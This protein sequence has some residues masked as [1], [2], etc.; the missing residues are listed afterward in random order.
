[1][2][3]FISTPLNYVNLYGVT[4]LAQAV[5]QELVDV[6][7]LILQR[8][9]DPNIEDDAGNIALHLAAKTGSS[10]MVRDR[11]YLL[12]LFSSLLGDF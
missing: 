8:G 5:D 12:G 7:K 6:C 2:L 4:A 3:D 11:E 9:G 10:D 1:M